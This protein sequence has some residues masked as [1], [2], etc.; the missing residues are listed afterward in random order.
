VAARVRAVLGGDREVDIASGSAHAA[1]LERADA[2]GAGVVA[3]GAGGGSRL[4]GGVAERVMRYAACP[5]LVA[6]PSPGGKVLSATDFSDPALPAVA[7]GAR[8]A[9]RR[10]VGFAVIHVIEA[11]VPI[12]PL[13]YAI[14]EWTPTDLA[15]ARASTTQRLQRS[16]AQV[17][18]AAGEALLGEGA[19][20]PAI[21]RAAKDLPAELLVVGT[22]G[23]TGLAR[24]ALGSTAVWVAR[25]APCSVLV[26]RLHPA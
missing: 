4:L 24:L 14:P 3:L 9:E 23:R 7:A 20:G 13:P 5:V 17:N 21:V 26:V 19:A 22:R 18:A 8:E 12:A 16:L 6:R 2:R 10:G 15:A 1:L 25:H 11:A